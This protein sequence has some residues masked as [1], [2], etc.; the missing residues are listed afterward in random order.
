MNIICL[1]LLIVLFAR[2]K[3]DKG[4]RS[5]PGCYD[6]LDIALLSSGGRGGIDRSGKFIDSLKLVFT[7][8]AQ[9]TLFLLSGNLTP[10]TLSRVGGI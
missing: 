3:V 6:A 9:L 1:C 5:P 10:D 7:L 4:V 2:Q 8:F